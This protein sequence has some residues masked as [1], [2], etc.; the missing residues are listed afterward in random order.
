MKRWTPSAA[1]ARALLV[2]VLL[3]ALPACTLFDDYLPGSPFTLREPAG[4]VTVEG[5]VVPYPILTASEGCNPGGT[6]FTGRAR[7][8][9][10]V[11]VSDV[12]ITLDVFDASGA[13]LG[14]FSGGIF[15]GTIAD[16]PDGFSTFGT[17]LE[18]DQLGAFSVCTPIPFGAAARTEHFTQFV[19][20]DTSEGG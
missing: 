6:V 9:G 11:G 16:D 10:D 18:I 2:A 5:E 19:V 3:A 8:T 4:E 20:V 12:S 1:T 13:V 7:N 14:S 15:N 17:D